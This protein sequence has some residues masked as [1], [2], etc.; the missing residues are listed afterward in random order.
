MAGVDGV[1]LYDQRGEPYTRVADGHGAMRIDIGAYERQSLTVEILPVASPTVTPVAAVT[2][3]FSSTVSGFDPGDLE[4]SLNGG[5]NLLTSGQTLS[6]TDNQTFILGG[7]AD[8]T[9]AAGYYT[10]QVISSGSEIVDAAGGPLDS[11]DSISWAMG[12][13]V[14]GLTVDTLVDEAD[15]SIDDG[16]ISLRDAIAAAAPGETIDFDA[17]LD[18]GTIL[19][20]LGELALTRA[21]TVDATGLT[22]GLILDA[23]GNDPTPEQDDG[24]GSRIFNI[25]DGDFGNQIAVEISGLTLTGGDVTGSGGAIF[26]RE[27]LTVTSSTLSGNSAA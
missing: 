3:Q 4:L 6:T 13:A 7:L 22:S 8:V 17:A 15:G 24:E 11:G 10:L 2:I 20:S 27:N 14:L 1:P 19:L 12:R 5:E 18:G 21:I 16:D 25:D 23:A 26:N 9:T